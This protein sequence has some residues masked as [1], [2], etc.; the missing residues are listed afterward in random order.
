MQKFLKNICTIAT[1]SAVIMSQGISASAD[2]FHFDMEKAKPTYGGGQ[3]YMYMT[4]LDNEKRDKNNFNPLWINENSYFEIDYTS[5]GEYENSPVLLI[6]QSWTGDLV[7]GTE[8][9]WVEVYPSELTDTYAKFTYDD[10]VS[11]Y[12]SDFSD[13]YGINVTDNGN[14]L[15]ISSF[16]LINCSYPKD[17]N[18]AE[19]TGG[20]AIR[21]DPIT[22]ETAETAPASEETIKD[23]TG[24]SEA[25]EET[26]EAVDEKAETET[27]PGEN[28]EEV[29]E[30][31]VEDTNESDSSNPFIITTVIAA[32]VIVILVIVLIILHK[33]SSKR[34]RFK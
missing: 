27:A 18:T 3:A 12:G 15:T 14:S 6:M 24:N 16:D 23:N 1:A 31:T 13:V 26:E 17:I 34:Y 11:A 9:K 4:R 25:V 2:E 20:T 33:K 21:T 30:E 29:N 5:E 19:I 8:V 32:V 22:T 10:I 28:V 7:D